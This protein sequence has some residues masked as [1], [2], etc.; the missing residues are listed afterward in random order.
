[1]CV[2]TY[3]Y[4]YIY[5]LFVFSELFFRAYSSIAT[6]PHWC[7]LFSTNSKLESPSTDPVG[8]PNR[9]AQIAELGWGLG[10]WFGV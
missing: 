9:L 7:S 5:N 3:I 10:L 8:I 1:M 4:I 6:L 2:L